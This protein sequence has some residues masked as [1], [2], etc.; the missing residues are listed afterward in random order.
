MPHDVK[1]QRS[2]MLRCSP[3]QIFFSWSDSLWCESDNNISRGETWQQCH[4]P[5]SWLHKFHHIIDPQ[6][7]R[8][9]SS[10]HSVWKYFPEKCWGSTGEEG[11]A[12]Q[13]ALHLTVMTQHHKCLW[14][15][16]CLNRGQQ[17]VKSDW[18]CFSSA[19]LWHTEPSYWQPEL[20]KFC[21]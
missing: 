2:H 10:S 18:T 9:S 12:Q 1:C 5:Q 8:H 20:T 13:H 17:L 3:W 11:G 21:W 7:G 4:R 16:W 6:L 19:A 15:K 14:E